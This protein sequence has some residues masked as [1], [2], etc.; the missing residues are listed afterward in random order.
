MNDNRIWTA[1]AFVDITCRYPS[2]KC[3]HPRVLKRD[4]E[5]HNLC[6]THR[7]KANRNQHRL[8]L[9]LRNGKP[10]AKRGRKPKRIATEAAVRRQQSATSTTTQDA[11]LPAAAAAVPA[12]SPPTQEHM[13]PEFLTTPMPLMPEPM[14]L[15]LE[16]M[17]ILDE[18]SDTTSAVPAPTVI[19][20]PLID[21]MALDDAHL[22][23]GWLD[24]DFQNL[25]TLDELQMM[26]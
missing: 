25:W 17:R 5:L 23:F 13:L 15:D 2:K 19:V 12:I 16:L 8:E 22:H 20:R 24:D 11:V 26:Q 14:P 4:G 10:P 6:E 7:R 21:S 9:K 3:W 1:A 18:F